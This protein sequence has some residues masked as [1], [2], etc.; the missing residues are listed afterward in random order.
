MAI[1]IKGFAIT[2]IVNGRISIGEVIEK[3]GKRLPK[4]SDEFHLTANYQIDGKWVQSEAEKALKATAKQ[5]GK[6]REIPVRIMFSDPENNFRAEYTAF[7][8][9]GRTL[10]SGNGET[11]RRRMNDGTVNEVACPSPDSCQFAKQFRCKAYGRLIVAMEGDFQRDPLAGFMFRTTSYNSIRTLTSRLNN[12]YAM[13]N[14][15]MAGFPATLKLKAKSTSASMRQAIYYVDLEPRADSENA[16]EGALKEASEY[17]ER[18]KE[19]GINRTALELAVAD[20]YARSAF[21]DDAD[22]GQEVIT[23][24]YNPEMIDTETGEIVPSGKPA[25]TSA[26][27]KEAD[28]GPAV[29]AGPSVVDRSIAKINK[30]SVIAEL[31]NALELSKTS[32]A[33]ADLEVIEKAIKARKSAIAPTETAPEAPT[34]S[35]PEMATA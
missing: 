29:P 15:L 16:M 9:D 12:I 32:F 27:A 18:C 35:A 7:Q 14:G 6:L 28:P 17:H 33:G 24:F 1:G 31:D 30:M 22:D 34:E 2:P 19:K 10:C 20:G 25:K 26:P 11:A 23:E 21:F 4:K 8:S 3:N 13:S 5:G